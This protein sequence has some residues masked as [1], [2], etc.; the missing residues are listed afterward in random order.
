M[1][2]PGMKP[3]AVDRASWHNGTHSGLEP[4]TSGSTV[5][6]SNHYTTAAQL[7]YLK[8][9]KCSN[10]NMEFDSCRFLFLFDLWIGLKNLIGVLLTINNNNY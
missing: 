5:Q 8:Y 1:Y 3:R 7:F 4:G 6:S 9:D 10:S 2:Y